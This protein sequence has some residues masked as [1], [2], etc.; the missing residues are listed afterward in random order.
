MVSAM[1]FTQAQYAVSPNAEAGLTRMPD[2]TR[3]PI[4]SASASQDAGFESGV[5]GFSSESL[6]WTAPFNTRSRKSGTDNLEFHFDC[7]RL[8]FLK[9]SW[10]AVNIAVI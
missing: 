5:F 4:P 3:S 7:R 10:A 9:A 1:I 8:E 2:A 6:N